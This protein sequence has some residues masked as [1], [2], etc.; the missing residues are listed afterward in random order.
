MRLVVV[1]CLREDG[2]VFDVLMD[3]GILPMGFE[4][5]IRVGSGSLLSVHFAPRRFRIGLDQVLQSEVTTSEHD[6]LSIE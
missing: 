5:L 2:V 6:R 3:S 4:K 1:G